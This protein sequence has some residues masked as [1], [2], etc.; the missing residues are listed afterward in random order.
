MFWIVLLGILFPPFGVFMLVLYFFSE[1]KLNGMMKGIHQR[2]MAQGNECS[3]NVCCKHRDRALLGRPNDSNNSADAFT[4]FIGVIIFVS[5][6][7]AFVVSIMAGIDW[8]TD[9]RHW[10]F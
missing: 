5:V 10:P 6:V 2:N 3:C 9:P 1:I 8:I 7:V 4:S